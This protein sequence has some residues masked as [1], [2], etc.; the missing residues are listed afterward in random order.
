MFCPALQFKTF[1][2]WYDLFV[3]DVEKEVKHKQV[4]E[5]KEH[6]TQ[7]MNV[8]EVEA[9]AFHF[10]KALGIHS[11]DPRFMRGAAHACC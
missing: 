10:V 8:F 9:K 7:T 4:L 2:T 11:S 1:K 3:R 5:S 6:A